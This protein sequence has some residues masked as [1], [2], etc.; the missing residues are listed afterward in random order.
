LGSD[1][2]RNGTGERASADGDGNLT[3]DGDVLPRGKEDLEDIAETVAGLAAA[4]EDDD[5]GADVVNEKGPHAD[6]DDAAVH[7]AMAHVGDTETKP[8]KR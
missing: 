4:D 2:D 7:E 3:L 6:F 1:T 8:A 5:G